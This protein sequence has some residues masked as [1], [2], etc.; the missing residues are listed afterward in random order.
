MN[1]RWR[2]WSF[3]RTK[4]WRKWHRPGDKLFLGVDHTAIVVS[5]TDASVKFY[6]D[7]IGLHAA[8]ESENYGTEQEHLNN[9]LGGY[10][11][12]RFAESGPGVELLDYLTPRDGRPFPKDEHA[13]DIVY[14][15]TVS[16]AEKC[17]TRCSRSIHRQVMFVSSGLVTNQNGKPGFS[18]AFVVETPTA[19]RLKSKRN[20]EVS[21]SR[22]IMQTVI[23]NKRLFL[24]FAVPELSELQLESEF[25]TLADLRLPGT[26]RPV[27]GEFACLLAILGNRGE[28]A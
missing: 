14:C 22:G 21:V 26:G 10:L 20:E 23:K 4:A 18:K 2:C 19:M 17:R 7:V 1:T 11:R 12:H 28:P 27:P 9:V 25:P 13:N 15:Q 24:E 8:G 3:L 6:R 16:S 5:D